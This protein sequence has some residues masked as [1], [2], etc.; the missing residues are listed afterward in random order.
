[1][2]GTDAAPSCRF[3]LPEPGWGSPRHGDRHRG[4]EPWGASVVPGSAVGGPRAPSAWTRACALLADSPRSEVGRYAE[5]AQEVRS[6]LIRH[7]QGLDVMVAA[8]QRGKLD[9]TAHRG[10]AAM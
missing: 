4:V 5:L 1:M 2:A 6:Q 9:P 7:V 3:F 10:I 8:I